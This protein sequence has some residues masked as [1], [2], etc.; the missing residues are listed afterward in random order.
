M[1]HSPCMHPKV[2]RM[3]C[4]L[5]C[6]CSAVI[7]HSPVG[8]SEALKSCPILRGS[9]QS[10]RSSTCL[11]LA[12][13]GVRKASL[14]F[15]WSHSSCWHRRN[16]H[17]WYVDR[18]CWWQSELLRV[19]QCEGDVAKAYLLLRFA[20]YCRAVAAGKIRLCT[21]KK[22]NICNSLAVFMSFVFTYWTFILKDM[23]FIYNI[24]I[25]HLCI[26]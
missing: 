9:S 14:V 10:D 20:V 21:V 26:Y 22:Q 17:D 19:M 4:L 16:Q 3:S 23:K 2:W 5:L 15:S 1:R 7:Y 8:P 24:F 11:H 18:V 12:C 13:I 25:M 6:V